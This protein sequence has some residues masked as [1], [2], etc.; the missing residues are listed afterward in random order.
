ML[1]K[2][3]FLCDVFLYV[4]IYVWRRADSNSLRYYLFMQKSTKREPAIN[5]GLLVKSWDSG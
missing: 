3:H 2:F 1:H 4:A 5:I